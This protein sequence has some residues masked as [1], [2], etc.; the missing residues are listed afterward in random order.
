MSTTKLDPSGH[1][2]RGVC[3]ESAAE[4]A[5]LLEN[6]SHPTLLHLSRTVFEA[7]DHR[8]AGD[9]MFAATGV[10]LARGMSTEQAGR[11]GMTAGALNVTR[12][13][14]GTGT[15]DEIERLAAHVTVWL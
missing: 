12:R 14:L 13:G 2:N 9:S 1:R 11:L 4:P 10:G 8:G 3:P 7:R 15:R 5:I 6:G